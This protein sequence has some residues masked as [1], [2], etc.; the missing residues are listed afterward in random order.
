MALGYDRT[1]M[2]APRVSE[3]DR[4][5][6]RRLGQWKRDVNAEALRKHLALSAQERLRRAELLFRESRGWANPQYKE[7]E[8][9]SI[10]DL[11]K[12]RGLYR[13]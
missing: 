4:E 9:R 2:T 3:R 5:Y 10:F 12:E 1:E 8:P 7:R 13:S 11:A 6:F